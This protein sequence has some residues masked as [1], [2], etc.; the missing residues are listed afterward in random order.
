MPPLKTKRKAKPSQLKLQSYYESIIEYEEQRLTTDQ[1][2]GKLRS[3]GYEGSYSAVRKFLELL[4]AEKKKQYIQKLEFR[5]S[6]TQVLSYIWNGFTSLNEE[7]QSLLKRCTTEF[8]DLLQI[9]KII[10][11][12]RNLFQTNDVLGL[13]VWLK[14]QLLNKLSPLHSHSIGIRMDLAA[15]KNAITSPYSNGLLEGQVN[16]LKWIKRMMYG[17]AKPDLLEKR[18]QYRF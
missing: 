7:K 13:T 10:Q 2:V 8:P 15:V 12:Y 9:E 17:R 14:K 4:R 18:M 1:I 5:V 6:R 16:R 3:E 11:D